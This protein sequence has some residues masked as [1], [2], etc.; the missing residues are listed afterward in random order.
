MSKKEKNSIPW[1]KVL[2]I[3]ETIVAATHAIVVL[4][5]EYYDKKEEDTDKK[6]DESKDAPED[7]TEE[8]DS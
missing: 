4:F 6:E 2:G 7:K 8:K 3:A 5:K 1:F